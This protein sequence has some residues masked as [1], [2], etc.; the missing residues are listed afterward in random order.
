[1]SL[2][3]ALLNTKI[4]CNNEYLDLYIEL[5]EKNRDTK[6]R[7]Y[8]TQKH[9]IIPRYFY[10]EFDK[11]IDNSSD[12]VVNLYYKDHVLAHYYLG[13]CSISDEHKYYNLMS[14]RHIF[15]NRYVIDLSNELSTE[16]L[17]N[18]QSLYEESIKYIGK[19]ISSKLK[20]KSKKPFTEEHKQNISKAHKNLYRW[21]Y[22]ENQEKQVLLKDIENFIALG[23]RFGR[24][25]Q[26]K[27]TLD[28]LVA[29]RKNRVY[30]NKDG[31]DKRVL[32]SEVKSYLSMGWKIGQCSHHKQSVSNL[33]WIHNESKSARVSKESVDNYLSN[34]WS[35]GRREK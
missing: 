3:E 22:K 18:I 28:K 5:I 7:K 12:N 11:A 27:E 31:R 26:T 23:W 14:I 13:M 4:F 29:T 20:G 19:R 34:G 10:R 33:V 25:K 6:S 8:K 1:M 2:K 17:T 24:L 15:G 16:Q 32:S 21:M 30:V 35:L 9:H